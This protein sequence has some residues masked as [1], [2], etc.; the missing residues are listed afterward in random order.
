MRH[1]FLIPPCLFHGRRQSRPY[2]SILD[3]CDE[4]HASVPVTAT[5]ADAIREMLDKRTGATAVVDENRVVAGIFTER[6]VLRKLALDQ[7]QAKDVPVRELMTTPVTLATSDISM[8]EAL[9][10]MVESHYRHLPI[11]DDHGRLLGMLSIRHVLQAKVDDLASQL[12][13]AQHA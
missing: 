12:Q 3:I 9:N 2:M 8:A 1:I 10:V 5:A 4:T 11:V 7:R 6:D 13:H